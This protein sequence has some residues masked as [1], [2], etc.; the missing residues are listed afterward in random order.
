MK[1]RYRV[2]SNS[3]GKKAGYRNTLWMLRHCLV[4]MEPDPA[5]SRKLEVL[6]QNICGDELFWREWETR[7]HRGGRRGIIIGGA[8][9]SAALPFM[10]V[11]AYVIKKHLVQRR[12]VPV[13]I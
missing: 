6:C 4:P 5:F 13:G 2:K 1:G 8:I 11:A 9:C 10:G 7:D 3:N 12:V